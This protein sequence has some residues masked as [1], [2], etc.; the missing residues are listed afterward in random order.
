LRNDSHRLLYASAA[1]WMLASGALLSLCGVCIRF[2]AQE[3]HPF[4]LAFFR[5]LFGLIVVAPWIIRHGSGLL[6]TERLGL[7]LFRSLSSL[8]SMLTFF[9][10]LIVLPMLTV[11]AIDFTAP[12]FASVAA[13]IVL[14][15]KLW[16]HR[17]CAL[18]LCLVGVA[19][20]ARPGSEL[21]NPNVLIVLVSAIAGAATIVSVKDL[22]RTDKPE[23]IV[24]YFVILM[25]PSSFLISLPVWRWPSAGLLPWIIAL[26]IAGTL[27][28]LLS[29]RALKLAEAAALAPFE[30]VRL[31]YA[32]ALGFFL[33]GEVPAPAT[34]AGAVIVVV[35]I[36]GLLQ[37]ELRLPGGSAA[38]AG[39][40]RGRPATSEPDMPRGARP[41]PTSAHD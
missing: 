16:L 12:I 20:I 8:I 29:A 31:L 40:G 23:T 5:N 32:A 3:L 30:Y 37:G 17:I 4:Q 34:V 39:L 18:A 38:E 22:S 7:Y 41:Q 11:M 14:G 13:A 21:F 10:G 25:I 24:C 27:A 15:E 33:Y 2:C 19:C 35:A 9:Y 6:R 28:H 26:G 36:A 1:G